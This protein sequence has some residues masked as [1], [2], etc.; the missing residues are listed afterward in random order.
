MRCLKL[1]SW[2]AAFILL[3]TFFSFPS[4]TATAQT[5]PA[6]VG[7]SGNRY[8]LSIR[9]KFP[10]TLDSI[11]V[12]ITSSP[13]WMMFNSPEVV[14]DSIPPEQYGEAMFDFSV[15]DVQAGLSD[16]V[17]L[18]IANRFGY[19]YDIRTVHFVTEVPS[20]ETGL[21]A[22]YPNPSNPS[23][24]IRYS[25]QEKQLVTLIIY[26]VLG[27][28][29][30]TLVSGEMDAGQHS[31]V[32]NGMDDHGTTAASGVYFVRLVTAGKSGVKQFTSKIL[33]LK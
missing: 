2:V 30:R 29:V 27:R 14:I 21:D 28:K 15:S 20:S 17:R 12:R 3:Q 10:W 7:T 19:G 8:I 31:V 5:N 6:P 9:N 13:Q 16:S 25:L 1:C 26:D 22:A 24:T 4:S 33:M 11:H 32:W 23:T 18:M